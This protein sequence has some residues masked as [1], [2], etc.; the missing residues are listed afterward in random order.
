MRKLKVS[1]L[2]GMMCMGTYAQTN[3]TLDEALN[4]IR[5]KTWNQIKKSGESVQK[6]EFNQ[7][8]FTTE[9]LDYSIHKTNRDNYSLVGENKSGVLFN[10]ICK[11]GAFHGIALDNTKDKGYELVSS[12]YGNSV[13]FIERPI[14]EL[15]FVCKRSKRAVSIPEVKTRK[16]IG[17]E[18][19]ASTVLDLESKPAA[20]NLIYLDFDGEDSLPGWSY[21]NYNAA[22][23]N[24]SDEFIQM[25]WES[26]AEDFAPFDV[27]IT[28]N[29]AVFDAH[30]VLSKSYVAI[31]QFGNMNWGGLA[32]LNSF[33]TGEP[34]LVDFDRAGTNFYLISIAHEL[35]HAL[36]LNHDGGSLSYYAGHGEYSPIMGNGS[37]FVSQ[38]SKGEYSGATNYE[39]DIK[40]IEALIGTATDIHL[41]N[42]LIV[43]ANDSVDP[44]FNTG[45]IENRS[46]VDTF[47]IDMLVDGDIVLEI[48]SP[49]FPHTNLDIKATLLNNSG[50]VVQTSSPVADRNGYINVSVTAGT[51]YLAIDGVG[52]LNVNDGFSDYGSLGYYQIS[53]NIGY[54]APRAKFNKSVQSICVGESVTFSNESFG[55]ALNYAWT[56]ENGSVQSSTDQHTTVTFNSP[57]YLTVS[58][59]SSNSGGTS[60]YTEKIH[61]GNGDVRILFPTEKLNQELAGVVRLSNDDIVEFTYDDLV[62]VN[63]DT[64]YFESCF[65]S[66]CYELDLANAYLPETCGEDLWDGRA[67]Q[68]GK[69]VYWKGALY[70]NSW[71]AEPTDEPGKGSPWVKQSDCNI[72]D[73]ENEIQVKSMSTNGILYSTNPVNAGID[74]SVSGS[75]C[76]VVTGIESKKLSF[77]I[78]PNPANEF[79]NVVIP[80]NP[81]HLQAVVFD[82]NG[83][84]VLNK[85]LVDGRLKISELEYGVY[86]LNLISEQGTNVYQVHKF[87]KM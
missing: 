82:I 21:G 5:S 26:V 73:T 27:N 6:I 51:Y 63:Q 70:K 54:L 40:I 18:E 76:E 59:E 39:D 66:E 46:D 10:L 7:E 3:L 50:T 24:V 35:G 85:T 55:S 41:D 8:Y 53:G 57:G 16:Y 60:V 31:A 15:T 25:S 11:N 2:L 28:T 23:P 14:G 64:A 43:V 65:F 29:R 38:W 74:L 37:N 72:T 47:Q 30:P 87:V 9:L 58:L 77:D 20:P 69:V 34:V 4:S 71:Y 45:V 75:F 13:T 19:T 44:E 61:V 56:F 52:E 84:Q 12:S 80:E 67:H 68:G 33:G 81:N 42:E 49:I 1:I 83:K 48:G 17:N 62:D 32:H 79:L 78:N 22:D 36:G 86:F